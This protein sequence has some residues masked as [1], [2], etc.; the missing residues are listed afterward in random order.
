M[1]AASSFEI[2]IRRIG[3]YSLC[4][5]AILLFFLCD[6]QALTVFI[7]LVMLQP[8]SLAVI[9]YWAVFNPGLFPPWLIFTLG[10]I[11]DLLIGLP[12]GASPVLFL[13][14]YMIVQRQ[15]LF[16]GSQSFM[17]LWLG[18]AVLCGGIYLGGWL[19]LSVAA[20]AFMPIDGFLLETILSVLAYPIIHLAC[21]SLGK[22]LPSIDGRKKGAV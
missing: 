16:L 19:I 5:C 14:L 15:R 17:L 20:R 21:A 9:F 8:L 18:Y 12:A 11:K 3:A 4:Y 10:L 22:I 2:D 7:P 13:A 1:S 6:L